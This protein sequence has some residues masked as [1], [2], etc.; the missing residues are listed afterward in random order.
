M[1]HKEWVGGDAV[2]DHALRFPL[3]RALREVPEFVQG[4]PGIIVLLVSQ[5]QEPSAFLPAIALELYSPKQ[6]GIHDISSMAISQ[7]ER[8]ESTTERFRR[9]CLKSQRAI[10]VACAEDDL[11]V[12]VRLAVDRVLNVGPMLASDLQAACKEMLGLRIS[13]R[14]ATEAL[15]YPWNYLW[16]AFRCGRNM[17]V[18]LTR[19]RAVGPPE[20][21]KA[22]QK[23]AAI[24][25]LQ[26]M[27]GYGEAQTW[28]MRLARDLGVFVAG[29]R[30]EPQS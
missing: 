2:C 3:R 27:H 14:Q 4:Q 23:S 1:T 28:G 22:T 30:S 9:N 7:N 11:P 10:V 8:K 21:P 25:M 20:P 5:D 6:T 18:V 13:K 19:L 15:T 17:D 29:T 24:P 26:D 16:D 12:P